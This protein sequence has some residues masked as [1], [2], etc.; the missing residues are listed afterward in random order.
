MRRPPAKI[1]SIVTRLQ[2]SVRARVGRSR[3]DGWTSQDH[4]T[5]RPLGSEPPRNDSVQDRG[6]LAHLP[7]MDTGKGTG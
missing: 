6:L 7:R 3:A 4:F 5:G 2:F 1:C